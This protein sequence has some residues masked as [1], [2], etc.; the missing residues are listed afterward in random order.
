MLSS[1][2]KDKTPATVYLK[3]IYVKY[4]KLLLCVVLKFEI[5][6]KQVDIESKCTRYPQT[7]VYISQEKAK[8]GCHSV[9]YK[10]QQI[11]WTSNI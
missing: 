5:W 9:I 10:H 11:W 6:D 3:W 8:S 4:W 2:Y 1:S 7:P